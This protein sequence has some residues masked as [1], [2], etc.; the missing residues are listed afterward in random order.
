MQKENGSYIIATNKNINKSSS[1][2]HLMNHLQISNI[3]NV[4]Y[5]ALNVYNKE[6]LTTFKHKYVYQDIVLSSELRE[7]NY[8]F[9]F[10][11]DSLTRCILR[12][13]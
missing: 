7:K 13:Y 11:I 10:D 6:N 8:D 2:K 1:L 5:F 12:I 3:D 4:H 9:N